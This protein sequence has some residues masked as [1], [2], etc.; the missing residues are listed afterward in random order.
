MNNEHFTDLEIK[1]REILTRMDNDHF[2]D[3]MI[4]SVFKSMYA[5]ALPLDRINAIAVALNN[6][7]AGTNLNLQ[8]G[9]TRLTR[10]KVLRSRKERGQTLYEINFS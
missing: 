2:D 3:M 10:Q 7:A 8:G 1:A 5:A 9:L 6:F 4:K